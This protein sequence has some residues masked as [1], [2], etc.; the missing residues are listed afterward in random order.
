MWTTL[1]R[2]AIAKGQQEKS[3]G[4][5]HDLDTAVLHHS[6]E[7]H[8]K[9]LQ[10]LSDQSKATESPSPDGSPLS[11]APTL[12]VSIAASAAGA[13]LLACLVIYLNN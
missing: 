8:H 5:D 12:V 2:E 6:W 10:E 1:A 13:L 3:F 11:R 4:G 7:V 9:A